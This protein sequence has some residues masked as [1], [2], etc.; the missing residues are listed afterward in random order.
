MTCPIVLSASVCTQVEYSYNIYIYNICIYSSWLTVSCVCAQHSS[1]DN[2]ERYQ[3]A[4]R[5]DVCGCYRIFEIRL[6]C[7]ESFI[8]TNYGITGMLWLREQAQYIIDN[9]IVIIVSVVRFEVMQLCT[10]NVIILMFFRANLVCWSF[11]GIEGYLCTIYTWGR[12]Y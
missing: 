5:C 10:H 7:D 2:S 4:P 6:S 12:T 8:Y 9:S 11:I 3:Y 1:D